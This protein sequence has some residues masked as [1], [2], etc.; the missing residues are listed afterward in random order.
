MS[1]R[2][3]RRE[4]RQQG[5]AEER[6]IPAGFGGANWVVTPAP[7]AAFTLPL[8]DGDGNSFELRLDQWQLA[9]VIV[10]I[11]LYAANGVLRVY[12][13]NWRDACRDIDYNHKWQMHSAA[14]GPEDQITLLLLDTPRVPVTVLAAERRSPDGKTLEER[15]LTQP[16]IGTGDTTRD[17]HAA[18][19]LTMLRDNGGTMHGTLSHFVAVADKILG[20]HTWSVLPGK[21]N[22]PVTA[23]HLVEPD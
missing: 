19:V 11:S 13:D 18:L 5:S 6:R 16:R 1:G 7:T 23:F 17:L 2:R 8:E 14:N 20:G 21:G 9:A 15:I 22:G 10:L 4:R 12:T 3:A